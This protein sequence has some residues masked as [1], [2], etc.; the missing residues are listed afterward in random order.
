MCKSKEKR[1]RWVVRRRRMMMMMMMMMMVVV[2]ELIGDLWTQGQG[3]VTE[4]KKAL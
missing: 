2:V 3:R 4:L 1:R